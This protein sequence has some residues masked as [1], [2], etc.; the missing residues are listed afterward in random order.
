MKGFK[1]IT[2]VESVTT[3]KKRGGCVFRALDVEFVQEEDEIRF[4]S[5]TDI[6]FC[7]AKDSVL[8]D[9]HC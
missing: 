7:Q 4:S 1:G 5:E 2:G 8:L 3:G 9:H 6:K